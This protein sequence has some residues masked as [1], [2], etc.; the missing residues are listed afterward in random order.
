MMR[1]TP[2]AGCTRYVPEM[3][4]WGGKAVTSLPGR[5][6]VTL[7]RMRNNWAGDPSDPQVEINNL[8]AELTQLCH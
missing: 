5:N 2:E 4:G 3:T 8:A 6:H 7:I 1:I